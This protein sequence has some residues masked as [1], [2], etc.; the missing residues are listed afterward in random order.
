MDRDPREHGP[1]CLRVPSTPAHSRLAG[2]PIVGEVMWPR[3]SETAQL[4]MAAIAPPLWRWPADF[5]SLLSARHKGRPAQLPQRARRTVGAATRTA[6]WETETPPSARW[7]FP[8]RLWAAG[9]S[10]PSR[11]GCCTFVL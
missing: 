1:H 9:R 5:D 2:R 10:S 8:P 7:T 6:L 11:P 4:T 3:R